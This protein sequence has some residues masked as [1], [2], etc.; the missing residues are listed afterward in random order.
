MP[1][2]DGRFGMW[3]KKAGYAMNEDSFLT[4]PGQFK[5]IYRP[6]ARDMAE[7]KTDSAALTNEDLPASW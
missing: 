2:F 4:L 6:S 7:R 5:G 1:A 3:L